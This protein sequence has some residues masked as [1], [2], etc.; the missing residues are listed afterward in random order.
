M[1]AEF[2]REIADHANDRRANDLEQEELGVSGR[3]CRSQGKPNLVHMDIRWHIL[4]DG[5][6]RLNLRGRCHFAGSRRQ[7][8][9]N[10]S[11]RHT[12]ARETA[13]FAD[14][15]DKSNSRCDGWRNSH[16]PNH[17]R[18]RRDRDDRHRSRAPS[19]GLWPLR[20]PSRMRRTL[21]NGLS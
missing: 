8:N 4:V 17:G 19:A 16:D 5:L 18:M 15:R 11:V 20:Q 21:A 14:R 6:Y 13:D 3:S 1:A 9:A 2:H 10:T 7:P 12:G